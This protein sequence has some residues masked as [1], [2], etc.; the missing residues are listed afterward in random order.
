MTEDTAGTAPYHFLH[1]GFPVPGTKA[2]LLPMIAPDASA[3]FWNQAVA[4]LPWVVEKRWG[5]SWPTDAPPLSIDP[6]YSSGR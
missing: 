1:E 5:E 2:R 3:R 4:L 6:G